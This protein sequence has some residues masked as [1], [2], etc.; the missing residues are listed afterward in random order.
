MDDF[1]PKKWMLIILTH[2]IEAE[3]LNNIAGA[4]YMQR[5]GKELTH[6]FDWEE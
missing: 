2:E 6:M 3:D 1:V 5:L 4:K